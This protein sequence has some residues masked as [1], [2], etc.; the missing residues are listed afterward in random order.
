MIQKKDTIKIK[1]IK[2]KTYLVSDLN[3]DIKNKKIKNQLFSLINNDKIVKRI[4]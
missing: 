2:T 3:I 4:L 1:K